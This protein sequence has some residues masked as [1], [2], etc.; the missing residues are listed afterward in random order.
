MATAST[1][2]GGS[3]ATNQVIITEITWV[4][5]Q[6]LHAAFAARPKAVATSRP[7]QFSDLSSSTAT[8][9]VKSW[10]WDFDGNNRVDST[11]QD[12]IFTYR[13][14]GRHLPAR[15][16]SEWHDHFFRATLAPWRTTIRE[17]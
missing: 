9:G 1:A 4:P 2:V 15:G 17:S 3:V 14:H 5:A 13:E 7:V 10:A 8:G 16:P 11:L 6:Y 12:P